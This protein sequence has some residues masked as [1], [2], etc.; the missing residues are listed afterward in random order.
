MTTLLISPMLLHSTEVLP[1]SPGW[2]HQ[3]KFDGVRCI[4][5]NVD[6]AINLWSRHGTPCTRQFP[7]FQSLRLPQ[8]V[9]LD[10][11]LIVVSSGW[12][13]FDA[14]ME[15]FMA[16]KEHKVARLSSATPTHFVTFDVLN[17]N[18]DSVMSRS[19]RER[20]ALLSSVVEPSDVISVCGR[21]FHRDSSVNLLAHT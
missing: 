4:L 5:A 18:G 16:K 12:T 17:I 20:Q 13:D 9:I 14:V 3:V 7:E 11:E 21:P 2:V 1:A 19:L 10:G 6:G 8:S 15:R